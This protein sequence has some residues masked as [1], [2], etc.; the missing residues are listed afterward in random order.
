MDSTNTLPQVT[1]GQSQKEATI[2]E[3]LA[4]A[5]PSTFAARDASGS[6]GLIW[7]YLGGR[8]GGTLVANGNTTLG[9]SVTTYQVSD[10]VT[11][12]VSFSTSSANWD[13]TSSYAR[14]YKIVTGASTVT[15]WEDHRL[16]LYGVI[17]AA[18]AAGL[19]SSTV[20]DGGLPDSTYGAIL[21]ING[22]TP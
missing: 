22:G 18:G 12:A 11:G 6:A 15:S 5:S 14:A 10:I 3:L 9:A 7:A 21:A 19:S 13:N 8:Y 20:I 2:N 17:S 16:G 4:A 1:V